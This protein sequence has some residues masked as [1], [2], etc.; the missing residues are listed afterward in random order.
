MPTS[1]AALDVLLDVAVNS[2]YTLNM[3]DKYPEDASMEKVRTLF[4]ASGLTMNDLGV[5]MG[6]D[7]DTARQSVFQFLKSGDPRVS[8]LRR[9]AKAMDVPLA[10]LLAENKKSRSR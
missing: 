5:K 4:A 8:M 3:K 10:E 1:L 2:V 9:F 7:P 6:Y